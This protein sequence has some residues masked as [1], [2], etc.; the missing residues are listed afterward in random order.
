MPGE[1]RHIGYPSPGYRS[2]VLPDGPALGEAC[3]LAQVLL[4]GPGFQSIVLIGA[5]RSGSRANRR[6]LISQSIHRNR[7]AAIPHSSG[8]GFGA[9][10]GSGARQPTMP[11]LSSTAR[12]KAVLASATGWIPNI[13]VT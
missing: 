9:Q 5:P 1:A 3:D 6:G 2:S 7:V 13:P 12:R 4:D 10:C 11:V 8:S